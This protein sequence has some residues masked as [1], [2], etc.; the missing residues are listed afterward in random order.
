MKSL[1]KNSSIQQG[2]V[3]DLQ[4]TRRLP[5]PAGRQ[6]RW[7]SG[8]R[9]KQE[10]FWI[11]FP[12]FPAFPFFLNI[13]PDDSP[14]MNHCDTSICMGSRR[15]L[16][17]GQSVP[18]LCWTELCGY[19]VFVLVTGSSPSSLVAISR[20]LYFWIFPVI[21]IGKVATNLMYFGTL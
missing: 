19:A 20:I 5:T 14:V 11:L 17:I 7:K 16:L 8:K 10:I 3:R 12:I 18:V 6:A 21:V 2:F 1:T 15:G 13:T 4:E 9:E